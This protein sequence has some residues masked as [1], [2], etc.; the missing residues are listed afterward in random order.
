MSKQKKSAETQRKV[1]D[2]TLALVNERGL[3]ATTIAAIGKRSATS[4]GSLYH[5]FGDREGILYALYR[6]SFDDCFGRL[7]PAVTTTERADDGINALVYT[8][9][10]WVAENPTRAN[11]IYAVSDGQQLRNHLAEIM[12]F[13][14]EFYAAI[15]A[16]MQ[17]FIAAGQL[18]ALPP[19]AYDAIIMGPAHEFARRWL[20]GIRDLPMAEAQ[21]IIAAVVWRAIQI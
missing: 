21:T 1:L 9:L 8:Y 16:W 5:H 19:W 12:Q 15:F 2:A 14:G 13:K 4:V 10:Q 20:A 18:I 7:L 6:E 11:F 17:P 3:H